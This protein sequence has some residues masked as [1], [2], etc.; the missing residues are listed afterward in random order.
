MPYRAESSS[1][2]PQWH[3]YP[4]PAG[5]RHQPLTCLNS[6]NA[7]HCLPPEICS[8]TGKGVERKEEGVREGRRKGDGR[9]VG[10]AGRR[11]S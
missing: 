9:L 8:A 7:W 6:W 1:G 11:D 10:V 5:T 4:G 2:A 3:S